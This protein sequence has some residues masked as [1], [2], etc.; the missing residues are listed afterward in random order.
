MVPIVFVWSTPHSQSPYSPPQSVPVCC[1]RL[2][3]P[4]LGHSQCQS[5]T[6]LGGLIP[7]QCMVWYCIWYCRVVGGGGY[8]GGYGGVGRR[9]WC[10]DTVVVLDEGGG[11]HGA[12][13]NTW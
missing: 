12:K 11:M 7:V 5:N 13:I 3:V 1:D 6:D 4:V 9:W 10:R 2:T 8:G